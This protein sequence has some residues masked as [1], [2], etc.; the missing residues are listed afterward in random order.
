MYF[1]NS[2]KFSYELG[3]KK[4]E[5]E[6]EVRIRTSNL[7]ISKNVTNYYF[8]SDASGKVTI[9]HA[10]TYDKFKSYDLPEISFSIVAIV[11]QTSYNINLLNGIISSTSLNNIMSGSVKWT[12]VGSFPP[13]SRWIRNSAAVNGSSIYFVTYG[14]YLYVFDTISRTT[15]KLGVVGG[16]DHYASLLVIGGTL[17]IHKYSS[18]YLYNGATVDTILTPKERHN[19]GLFGLGE[20]VCRVG[21]NMT[22]VYPD[23]VDCYDPSTETWIDANYINEARWYPGIVTTESKTV[24]FGGYAAFERGDASFW[25]SSVE[26]LDYETNVWSYVSTEL[27]EGQEYIQALFFSYPQ[28]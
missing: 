27:T 22:D 15:T 12:S 11:N 16:I 18:L 3:I 8:L 23:P 4:H 2:F 25:R 13:E 6:N 1:Q 10:E 21:G 24:V 20:K 28:S 9:I 17:Y 7:D 5:H 26:V 14:G 19:A